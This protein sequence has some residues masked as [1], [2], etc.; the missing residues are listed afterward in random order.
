MNI[1]T[2]L[3]S[4]LLVIL[5]LVLISMLACSSDDGDKT[6]PA[7]TTSTTGEGDEPKDDVV[8]TIGNLSDQTGPAAAAMQVIDI[9]FADLIR[10]FN[11][12]NRET[13]RRF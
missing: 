3:A 13:R 4:I 5:I 2:K 8:F 6:M 7:T 9:A 11:E 1:S 12:E 10:H